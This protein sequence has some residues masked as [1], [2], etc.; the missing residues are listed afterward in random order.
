[1]NLKSPTFTDYYILY[2]AP[3][4]FP[5][6]EKVAREILNHALDGEKVIVYKDK[7]VAQAIARR[8]TDGDGIADCF[9]ISVSNPYGWG[10]FV[11]SDKDHSRVRCSDKVRLYLD[12]H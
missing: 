1:M 10:V 6:V 3:R 11:K 2:Y 4:S 5:T 9:T 8:Q 7:S 12:I